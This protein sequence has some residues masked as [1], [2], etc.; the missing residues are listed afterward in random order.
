SVHIPS[1]IRLGIQAKGEIVYDAHRRCFGSQLIPAR[2]VR[3]A[4]VKETDLSPRDLP[5][6]HLVQANGEIV[7]DADRKR[8]GSQCVSARYVRHAR[9]NWTGYKEAAYVTLSFAP[10]LPA[11]QALRPGIPGNAAQHHAQL[12]PFIVHPGT[13]Q[14]P[15]AFRLHILQTRGRCRKGVTPHGATLLTSKFF[16]SRGTTI[17]TIAKLSNEN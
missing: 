8:F 16:S 17:N 15:H 13:E 10:L 2:Y 1:S 12:H 4:H 7:H 6:G 11:L 5:R 9:G 14:L 3:H